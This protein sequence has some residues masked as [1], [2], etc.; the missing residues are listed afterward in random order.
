M[1][2]RSDLRFNIPWMKYPWKVGL[3]DGAHCLHH[4]E[5]EVRNLSSISSPDKVE[6]YI[7]NCHRSTVATTLLKLSSTAEKYR[8]ESKTPWDWAQL[9]NFMFWAS[10]DDSG[11]CFLACYYFYCNV[12]NSSEEDLKPQI[13]RASRVSWFWVYSQAPSLLQ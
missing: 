12:F 13:S 10:R 7:P 9:W 6:I 11:T 5:T 2:G 3:N 1:A 4:A 8:N